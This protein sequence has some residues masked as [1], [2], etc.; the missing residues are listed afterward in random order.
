[1]SSWTLLV[2]SFSNILVVER[3]GNDQKNHSPCT[4]A[5]LNENSKE[6]KKP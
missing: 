4:P 6:Y 5:W 3:T 2:A 1:M